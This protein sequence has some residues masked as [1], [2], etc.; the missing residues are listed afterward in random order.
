MNYGL[1][2]LMFPAAMVRLLSV[3]TRDGLQ[4]IRKIESL[5]GGNQEG[6]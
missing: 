2:F 4:C 3:I 6:F 5:P 1:S